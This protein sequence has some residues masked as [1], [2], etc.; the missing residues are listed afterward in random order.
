M[1][2]AR[3]QPFCRK[4]NNKIGYYDGYREYPGNIAERNKTLKIHDRHFFLIW[5]SNGISFDKAIR[6]L[7]GNF[8]IVDNVISDKRFKSSVKYEYK[9]K[10]V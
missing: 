9:R 3:N 2:S 4:F 7:K 1:T 5:K 10:K 8:E 6:E